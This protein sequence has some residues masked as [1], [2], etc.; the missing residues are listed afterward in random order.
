MEEQ[1]L[2]DAENFENF[3]RPEHIRQLREEKMLMIRSAVHGKKSEIWKPTRYEFPKH[4]RQLIVG[5]R[6][7]DKQAITKITRD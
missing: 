3:L 5:N 2:Q 1:L 7:N 4:I 6:E